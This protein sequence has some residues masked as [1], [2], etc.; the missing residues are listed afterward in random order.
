MKIVKIKQM[1]NGAHRNQ[2]GWT[3]N[4]P[5][6]WAIVPDGANLPNFPFGTMETVERGGARYVSRWT[7]LPIP[8]TPEPEEDSIEE[9][10]LEMAADHEERLCMLELGL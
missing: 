4:V 3:G 10:L 8:P 2:D 5:D 1:E 7:A 6:G 9:L